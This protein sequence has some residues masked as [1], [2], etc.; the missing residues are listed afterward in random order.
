MRSEDCKRK[1][2][3]AR[4]THSVPI[5]HRT[6]GPS[7]GN[8][9]YAIPTNRFRGSYASS[10]DSTVRAERSTSQR[11]EGPGTSSNHG[12]NSR[13]QTVPHHQIPTRDSLGHNQSPRLE[14]STAQ[15]APSSQVRCDS[16]ERPNIEHARQTE[17]PSRCQA[18]KISHTSFA[19]I[20]T[21]QTVDLYTP[22]R[23]LTRRNLNHAMPAL[24]QIPQRRTPEPLETPEPDVRRL[25]EGLRQDD[26]S[27]DGLASS[28]EDDSYTSVPDHERRLRRTPLRP[29]RPRRPVR[30]KAYACIFACFSTKAV[31]LE[32]Y[33]DLTTP[34]FMS[35]FQ[36][37]TA[38]RGLP[39]HVYSDSGTNFL[40]ASNKIR[41]L[42]QL[43]TID[44]TQ[45]SISH[46]TTSNNITWHFSPP[47]ALH[48]GGLWE[49]GVKVMK[50]LLRKMVGSHL[51]TFIKLTTILSEA[52]AVLNSRPIVPISS[53]DPDDIIITPGHFLI[54]RPLKAAPS[55]NTNS[56]VPIT[57][58]RR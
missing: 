34:E 49:A 17:E 19:Q 12:G 7:G 51:L 11:F 39:L 42:R 57:R 25:S 53:T 2:A 30:I 32:L 47:R 28:C 41:E 13:H 55:D 35:A 33:A 24:R 4:L 16:S 18:A 14:N 8:N 5:G 36:R 52:E 43:L 1:P 44:E 20:S 6:P 21:D 58:L 46:L 38:R 48:F 29:A 9:I 27:E 50:I 56:E 45:K 10:L 15:T 22:S 3:V 31:H 40:G 26:Q 37:F 23:L 54:S